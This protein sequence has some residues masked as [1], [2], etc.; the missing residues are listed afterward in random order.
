M[1]D[2]NIVSYLAKGV[3]KKLDE[4]FRQSSLDDLCISVVTEA[5]QLYGFQRLDKHH[6]IR[7][8]I[9]QLMQ[10][11]T[12]IPWSS[13]AAEAYAPIRY[14]LETTRQQI[15]D[16]D[17]M[18]AAHALSLGATLVTHNVEHFRRVPG[19]LLLEDWMEL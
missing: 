17:T 2:T 12:I 16:L 3:S 19:S 14:H 4:R 13:E 5:E 6:R 10:D 11:L 15:G 8:V 9:S 7:V 1:L 18:I